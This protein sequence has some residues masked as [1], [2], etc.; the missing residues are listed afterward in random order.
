[1]TYI[2]GNGFTSGVI[3]SQWSESME[4]GGGAVG[5]GGKKEKKE[6]IKKNYHFAMKEKE[7]QLQFIL[8]LTVPT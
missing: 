5:T 1:M 6:E 2:H 3:F 8:T 4:T 7:E